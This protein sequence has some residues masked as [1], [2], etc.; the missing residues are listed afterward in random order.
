NLSQAFSHT[1]PLSDTEIFFT[2]EL[3]EAFDMAICSQCTATAFNLSQAF[4]HT[5]PLSDTEIFFTHELPE[6]FDMAIC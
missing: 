5:H 4:S 1:H 3:P 2:H 6:A